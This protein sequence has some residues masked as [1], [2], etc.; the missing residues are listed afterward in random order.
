MARPPVTKAEGLATRAT[1]STEAAGQ[2]AKTK[3]SQMQYKSAEFVDSE[4]DESDE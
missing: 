4:D 1:G 2:P 3:V